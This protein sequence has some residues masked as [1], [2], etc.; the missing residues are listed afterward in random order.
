MTNILLA[1][2][3]AFTPSTHT[4]VVDRDTLVRYWFYRADGV[5]GP[6]QYRKSLDGGATWGS[7]VVI[8]IPTGAVVADM[9]VWADWWTPNDFGEIIHIAIGRQT[10]IKDVLY[11]Q[12]DT[13][14][15]TLSAPTTVYAPSGDF[16]SAPGIDITKTRGG[17]LLVV[18]HISPIGSAAIHKSTNNGVTWN[19]ISLFTGPTWSTS[20][21]IRIFPGNEV[22][23]NDVWVIRG[24][25][26]AD[27]GFR[28]E[29][30]DD[31]ADSWSSAGRFSND[32]TGSLFTNNGAIRHSDGHLIFAATLRQGVAGAE[33]ELWDI[34]G[35]ASII[36]K[37]SVSLDTDHIG[38][39]AIQIDQETDDLRVAYMEGTALGTA[40]E[41]K[42]RHSTDGGVSWGAV[43]IF[44][45]GTDDEWRGLFVGRS[46]HPINGGR[47]APIWKQEDFGAPPQDIF[48][49]FDNSIVLPV[50]C[51]VF[52]SAL[53]PTNTVVAESG[54]QLWEPPA[55]FLPDWESGV[56]INTSWRTTIQASRSNAEQR[57]GK[58]NKPY[59][60]QSIRLRG[61]GA[62]NTQR[63]RSLLHRLG[64][65]RSPW[66]IFSDAAILIGR[67]T[68]DT[69]VYEVEDTQFRRFKPC[70]RAVALT[71]S[72]CAIADAFKFRT[73]LN[74]TPTTITLDGDLGDTY[75]T[76]PRI[77]HEHHF[78]DVSIPPT[79]TSFGSIGE[80]GLG[81]TP[82]VEVGQVV[83]V[84]FVA[85]AKHDH[86]TGAVNLTSTKVRRWI[87]VDGVLV[88]EGTELDVS[89]S[90]IAN[91]AVNN[92]VGIV[93]GFRLITV[94]W[95]VPPAWHQSRIDI[96]F[97]LDD[98][99]FATEVFFSKYIIEAHQF[100]P[101]FASASRQD[102][103]VDT[104]IVDISVATRMDNN[105]IL[106]FHM[107]AAR[108]FAEFWTA[109]SPGILGVKLGPNEL[110]F[111]RG[112]IYLS[113]QYAVT[114][115]AGGS[116]VNM[117]GE[118]DIGGEGGENFAASAICLQQIEDKTSPSRG[119][120]FPV[121][122]CAVEIDNR[123]TVRTDEVNEATINLEETPG[124]S[125]LDPHI[126]PGTTPA[127]FTDYLGDPILHLPINWA[128]V[129]MGVHRLGK[130]ESTGITHTFTAFGERP[131]ETFE[132]PFLFNGRAAIWDLL[133]FF[134]SRAGRLH[135]FW[136]ISPSAGV[137]P[138]SIT[139]GDTIH[140]DPNTTERDWEI[141][142]QIGVRTVAT[143]ALSIHAITLS[144]EVGGEHLLTISP[145]LPTS[146]VSDYDFATAHLCRFD[147]EEVGEDWQTD[148]DMQVTLKVKELINEKTVTLPLLDICGPGGGVGNDP[149]L[150]N[151][152]FDLCTGNRCGQTSGGCCL[153]GAFGLSMQL[154]CYHGECCPNVGCDFDC[155]EAGG[156]TVFLN[157]V[158]CVGGVIRWEGPRMTFAELDTA[159]ISWTFSTGTL[160]DQ[161]PFC[162]GEAFTEPDVGG[163]GIGNGIPICCIPD[164]NACDGLP[165]IIVTESCC[166]YSQVKQC[167][168]FNVAQ[169]DYREIVHLEVAG[170]CG[171]GS[172]VC[173]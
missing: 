33:I 155:V 90:I 53:V 88:L 24:V 139:G 97:T 3:G 128:R 173:A 123:A 98:D 26:G 167:T 132:L 50:V 111:Q 79:T 92:A 120:I 164:P 125:G 34:N 65:S 73:I 105:R 11:Y 38:R 159:T 96:A 16:N 99:E 151:P 80:G 162:C 36:Q 58:V 114:G 95:V 89:A 122:E 39:S 117:I 55:I 77:V 43:Q 67:Q 153:C 168:R 83:V 32:A 71:D 113:Q 49:S 135:P 84:N 101:I 42:Y 28:L 66:P 161:E 41:C 131:G 134:D 103:G 35:A 60:S 12:L 140:L 59:R 112:S 74:V 44:S 63:F 145:A 20:N 22:D 154:K 172:P 91:E 13:T 118:M 169:C 64:R 144:L 6:A 78:N 47:W 52:P 171:S 129:R 170:A 152:D 81:S 51:N 141:Y 62:A 1:S 147:T 17:N 121:M 124:L 87:L 30:Y 106:S 46:T 23:P 158:S 136:L 69:N 21:H 25:S 110:N 27:P 57:F 100:V 130:R 93:P 72:N 156:C 85:L 104:S 108:N 163:C 119:F 116:P 4:D 10:P 29:T 138:T 86:P 149:W 48:T 19:P 18:S 54:I 126:T 142:K 61:L 146:D 133:T 107:G 37:T 45:V 2:D 143:G 150:P 70:A 157:F 94:A 14:D 5:A 127:G 9:A 8:N 137:R 15:D 148:Q 166:S 160:F 102:F 115:G 31:S 68:P 165:T 56:K 82:V 109:F 40:M 7:P 76:P 75:N